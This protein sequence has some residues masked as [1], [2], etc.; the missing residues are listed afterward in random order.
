MS[1][2]TDLESDIDRKREGGR[3]AER[4]KY[5]VTK[6]RTIAINCRED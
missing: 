2:Y 4:F 3:L 5:Y 6:I 1:E